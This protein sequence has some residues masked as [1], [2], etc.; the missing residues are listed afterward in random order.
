[1]ADL[2]ALKLRVRDVVASSLDEVAFQRSLM[3]FQANAEMVI[4]EPNETIERVTK[5]FGF[6]EDTQ[7]TLLGNLYV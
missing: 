5:R 1:M 2:E 6:S 3:L 7:K 4:P